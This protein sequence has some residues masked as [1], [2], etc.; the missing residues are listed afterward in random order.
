MRWKGKK[1]GFTLIEVL[2][3]M[4]IMSLLLLSVYAAYTGTLRLNNDM[5]YER[6]VY[7]MGRLTME[8]ITR[9]LSHAAM[10]R[11]CVMFK[12]QKDSVANQAFQDLVFSTT[13]GVLLK[14]QQGGD[15][16]LKHVPQVKLVFS[17]Y[18]GSPKTGP[19]GKLV[20]R[21]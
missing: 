18:K 19:V 3:S 1:G 12:S 11:G 16:P 6:E 7:S 4:V 8:I 9:D 20:S 17:H 2:I 14:E 13:S 10:G 15:L 21:P 5:A